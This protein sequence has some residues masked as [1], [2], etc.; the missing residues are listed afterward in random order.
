ML[1]DRFCEETSSTYLNIDCLL[2]KWLF[3]YL[4]QLKLVYGLSMLNGLYV[5]IVER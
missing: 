1:A 3:L 2:W 4:S 5:L